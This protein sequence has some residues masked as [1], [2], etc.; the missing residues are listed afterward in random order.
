MEPWTSF[1]QHGHST[2]FGAFFKDGYDGAIKHWWRQTIAELP[3]YADIL[4]IGCGNAALLIELLD[5]K[6]HGTY[7]GV[8]LA[9][10]TINEVAKKKLEQSTGLRAELKSHTN[11][12]NLPLESE[13][14]DL[15]ASVFGIEY[16]D[17]KKSLPE[18]LRV[19]KPNGLFHAL[20]HAAD[21]VIST[22]SARAL[23]EFQDADMHKIVANIRVIN[24]EIDELRLPA[25]LKQS[26]I[27]ENA[28]AELNDLAQKYMSDLHPDTGNAIMVQFVGD[29]L[30]YFKILNQSDTVR[31]K[32]IDG[33]ESEFRASR[34]RYAA[35]AEAAKSEADIVEIESLLQQQKCAGIN[36]EK[37]FADKD[38]KELGGWHISVRK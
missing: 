36:I 18:A 7:T 3:P 10:V 14:I 25:R 38:R 22:M 17:L 34:R 12:E 8:D 2:T 6:Q 27:A 33:L 15:A 4:D 9:G 23:S 19:L 37:F 20:I 16:S 11:A 26:Q 31:S 24:Q 30:K 1:W 28:R 35:M 21:S 29:A 32:Y 13:S 5:S